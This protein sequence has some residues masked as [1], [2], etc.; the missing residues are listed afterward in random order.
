MAFEKVWQSP[1]KPGISPA[2]VLP[3]AVEGERMERSELRIT[4]E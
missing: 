3:P 1:Q 4:K 2:C